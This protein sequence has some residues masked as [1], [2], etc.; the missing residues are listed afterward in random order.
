MTDN[1]HPPVAP[2]ADVHPP[3]LLGRIVLHLRHQ[4]WTAIAIEFVVV[5]FG[6]LLGLQLN[7]WNEER[8]EAKRRAEIVRAVI[9]NLNDAIF[10][11]EE[12]TGQIE[13]G[14]AGWEKAYADGKKPIPYYFRIN[15][16]YKAPAV[17]STFEQM[18]LTDMFDPVTVFDLSYFYS[19]LGG[20]GD[21]YIR[22]A[23]FLEDK[24]L[25][26][27]IDGEKAFYRTDGSLMPEYRA[28][29]DR[30]RDFQKESRRQTNWARCLIYRLEADRTYD[31]NCRRAN[32]RL[33][34]EEPT[35]P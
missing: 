17:W 32:Y 12:M 26:G 5:V 24:V 7:N 20:I 28:N 11:Q 25:P 33:D 21:R 35:Q 15:G 13:T 4:H 6:V 27:E 16:A 22:Y 29:M 19:E 30:L 18:Q 9:T 14:L 3:T 31:R 8:V 2:S 34:I 1:P 10:A 23:T